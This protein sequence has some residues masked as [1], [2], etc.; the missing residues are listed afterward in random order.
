MDQAFSKFTGGVAGFK[1][2]F[3]EAV[4]AANAAKE[5]LD[6]ERAKLAEERVAFEHERA[7]IAQV[8]AVKQGFDAYESVV[9]ASTSRLTGSGNT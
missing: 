3:E 4:Q 8:Y 5:E 2:T 1:N 9:E 7:R 6:R